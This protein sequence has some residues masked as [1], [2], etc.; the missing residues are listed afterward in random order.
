MDF[1]TQAALPVSFDFYGQGVV[2]LDTTVSLNL[3][4]DHQ[5]GVGYQFLGS[6]ARSVVILLDEDFDLS[7][8][9]E[10]G[11]VLA[12]KIAG[13]LSRLEGWDVGVSPPQIWTETQIRSR[14]SHLFKNDRTVLSRYHFRFKENL[15]PVQVILFLGEEIHV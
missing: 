8:A 7:V 15:I 6:S 9:S 3:S 5:Q 11:N 13:N 10:L 14:L 4:L 12:A 2:S 1:D